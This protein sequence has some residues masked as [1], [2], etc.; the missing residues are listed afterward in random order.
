[1]PVL[2][3]LLEASGLNGPQGVIFNEYMSSYEHDWEDAVF[4]EQN[5]ERGYR[6]LAHQCPS[7]DQ[8]DDIV[9]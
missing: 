1:M 8:D 2:G 4:E 3:A 9:F 6:E 7:K 5:Y